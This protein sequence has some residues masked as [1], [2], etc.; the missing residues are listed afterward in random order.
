MGTLQCQDDGIGFPN[1]EY[2]KRHVLTKATEQ[3]WDC[4]NGATT[5]TLTENIAN[6]QVTISRNRK[7]EFVTQ[8]LVKGETHL[9][10]WKSVN[11]D[12]TE[13]TAIYASA[14]AQHYRHLQKKATLQEIQNCECECCKKTCPCVPDT[15]R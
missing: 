15:P 7:K 8:Q 5:A 9:T 14:E 12:Q 6:G 13:V 10:Q 11:G 4:N 2:I 3:D 1:G